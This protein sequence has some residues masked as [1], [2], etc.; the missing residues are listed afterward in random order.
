M[1]HYAQ[2]SACIDVDETDII[3]RTVL[4]KDL[5]TTPDNTN[6]HAHGYATVHSKLEAEDSERLEL[7]LAG[8]SCPHV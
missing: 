1:I 8:Q 4:W 6:I 5:A 2:L 3:D 7:P